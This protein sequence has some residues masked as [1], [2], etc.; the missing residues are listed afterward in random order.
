MKTTFFNRTILAM[1]IAII[2]TFTTWA[3]DVQSEIND[4]SAPQGLLG[5]FDNDEELLAF[6]LSDIGDDHADKGDFENAID[7][8]TK[9]K[10]KFMT[11]GKEEYA[12][13]ILSQIGDCQY[14]VRNFDKAIDAYTEAKNIYITL[15]NVK[16]EADMLSSIADC[17][18]IQG[19]FE[20]A[21]RY[22]KEASEKYRASNN[23]SRE[24]DML[25]ADSYSLF[26]QRD[27]V[28]SLSNFK[29][30]LA[31]K[32]PQVLNE[33]KKMTSAERKSF[34]ENNSIYYN[35]LYPNIVFTTN[36]TTLLGDM[37][38]KS[39]L[40]AKGML[41]SADTEIE[42]LIDEYGYSAAQKTLSEL[43]EVRAK[44][45]KLYEIKLEEREQAKESFERQEE[46]L[47]KYL[48]D[49]LNSIEEYGDFTKNLQLSWRNVKRNLGD[50]DRR[51]A[52]E[53]LSFPKLGTND[54]VYIALTIRDND[55]YTEPKMTFLC[56]EKDLKAAK[57]KPYTSNAL[58]KLIWAPLAK[59]LEDVDTIYFSPSGLL[60][61]IAIESMPHWAEKDS[62]MCNKYK[63]YRLSSTRELAIKRNTVG[64][65]K[66]LLYGGMKYSC[67]PKDMIA[68]TDELLTQEDLSEYVA[69]NDIGIG[70]RLAEP[71]ASML[72]GEEWNDLP[73][74]MVKSIKGMLDPKYDVALICDKKAT[75]TSF[76]LLSKKNE[77]VVLHTHGFYWD[78]S[79]ALEETR[80]RRVNHERILPF[81][82]IDD[83]MT[84]CGL[85]FNGANNVKKGATIPSGYD[86]GILIAQEVANLDLRGLDLLVLSACQTG[87]GE[88]GS[89][90]V[91]GL[92]RGFK[93]AGT[94]SII[95]SLW[96]V[97]SKATEMM[98]KE[99][100]KAWAGDCSKRE[101]FVN[102]QNEVKKEY[103]NKYDEEKHKGPHWAAFILLDALEK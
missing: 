66:A 30:G 46:K 67:L 57:K 9:A 1:A 90:G 88:I 36:D 16:L 72:L 12:A 2:S 55:K 6:W 68:A 19:N 65:N 84:R 26:F 15:H 96:E 8:Y 61:T 28:N 82:Q 99:F 33:L 95:M 59:E 75:E 60:H 89:D 62:L 97:D 43:K 14:N 63:I 76:K 25:L 64:T 87:D 47:E 78:M 39:L 34:W 23:E 29:K 50:S 35:S 79:K 49:F 98:M 92:Q 22:Y 74:T 37:Y 100:F 83:A 85:A 70:E 4:Y 101:A 38:D 73:P 10:N 41:I 20:K 93:K 69:S 40:F 80:T 52:I 81:M 7:A 18:L 44:Q 45:T 42:R 17:Y 24:A 54:T 58:S 11:L 71:V 48:L 94:Q 103:G 3:H 53:F 32:H 102:A 77:I 27:F 21:M 91:F 31:K 51:I 5:F 86:D 13:I 56:E